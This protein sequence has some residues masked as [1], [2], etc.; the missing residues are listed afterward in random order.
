LYIINCSD[1]QNNPRLSIIYQHFLGKVK[2]LSVCVYRIFTIRSCALPKRGLAGLDI[3]LKVMVNKTALITS[4]NLLN[5]IWPVNV[6]RLPKVTVFFSVF[7]KEQSGWLNSNMGSYHVFYVRN[8][9]QTKKKGTK[10]LFL[11]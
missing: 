8:Y 4:D 7:Q 1:Y 11:L 6:L 2:K 5:N 3:Y 9:L 10:M